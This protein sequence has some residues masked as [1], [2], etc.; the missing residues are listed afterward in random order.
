MDI[1]SVRFDNC[2]NGKYAGRI[3]NTYEFSREYRFGNKVIYQS[4]GN[5]RTMRN[6]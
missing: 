5:T 3:S 6:V 4:A 1:I 2:V